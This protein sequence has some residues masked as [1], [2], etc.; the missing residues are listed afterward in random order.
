[1]FEY[2]NGR[3]VQVSRIVAASIYNKPLNTVDE[4]GEQRKEIRVAIE[5]DVAQR[6]NN[7]LFGGPFTDT[8]AARA[9]ILSIPNNSKI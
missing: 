4:N 2:S 7:T 5:I 9:F 3:F 1:M 6:E 8:E